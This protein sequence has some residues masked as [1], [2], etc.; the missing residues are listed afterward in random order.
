MHEPE[1]LELYFYW[2][3]AG[4]GS[5]AQAAQARQ[6]IARLQQA[7]RREA[8]GLTCRLLR[9]AG[10]PD[11]TWMEIYTR[12]GGIDAALRERLR[13]EGDAA[14]APWLSSARHLE[15]FVPVD[16]DAPPSPGTA[17]L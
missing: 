8:P 4:G 3:V 13:T 1:A 12:P 17:A 15:A 9:R 10:V 16:P 7:W 14:L 2:R 6:V 5:A 11:G